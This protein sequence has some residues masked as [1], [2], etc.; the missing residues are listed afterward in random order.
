MTAARRVWD[1]KAHE[2]DAAES[3]EFG[4]NP[5]ERLANCLALEWYNDARE[6]VLLE[7][8]NFE[9]RISEHGWTLTKEEDQWLG[10]ANSRRF[11]AYLLWS[12]EESPDGADG[13]AV[14][15]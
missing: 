4:W 15:D 5:S 9:L 8:T 12:A 6:R 3:E 10:A 2:A 11:A 1:S 13:D 14:G 7:S